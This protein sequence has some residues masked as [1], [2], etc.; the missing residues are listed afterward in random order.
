MAITMTETDTTSI[1]HPEVQVLV[2]RCAGC[3]ECVIRC[4]A[5]ALDMDPARWV[6]VAHD[7]RCVGCRQCV[8][9]CPFSAIEVH[10]PV[11]AG[12][13]V[14][15]EVV[16]PEPLLADV[17]E[18]RLGLRS[19]Q[20]AI[21]E[22]QRC[23]QC[24]D[25]T[26]VR[27]CPAHNDIPAFVAAVA[28]RDLT[29][30]HEVLRRTSVLPDVCARVCNQSAQCEG[31]CTWSLAGGVPVAIGQLERFVADMRPVPP[32]VRGD[33][34]GLSVA[35]VGAGPGGIGA[36]WALV[37]GGASVTV[38]ERDPV[39]AGLLGWG[40]PD[41]TLPETVAARPWRQL[42]DAGVDLHCGVE[43]DR[44]GLDRLL[45][46]H[47]AVVVATGASVP[48]RLPIPGADLDGVTD[49][50]AFLKSARRALLEGSL[51]TWRAAMGLDDAA[52]DHVPHVLVL[53]AGNTA[54]DVARTAR[55]LGLDA[56]CVDWL[57]ERF[58]LARPDEVAEAREEGVVV[59]FTRTVTSIEGEHG[60]VRQARLAPTLQERATRT[61]KVLRDA[62]AE[63]LDVDLV[64]M[65]M[66]YRPDP[67]VAG[68]LPGTPVRRTVRGLPDR[69]WTA[70]GLLANPASTFAF[71]NPVGRLALGREAGLQ[72]ASFPV[73]ER[74]WVVGDALVG[75]STVVEA[76]AQGR[77]A[78]QA[79]LAGRPSRPGRHALKGPARVLVCYASLGGR[80]AQ[81]ARTV[82]AELAD[83]GCAVRVLPIERVGPEELAAAD[84]LV[85]GTWVKGLVV[86]KVG[87]PPDVL[88]WLEGL[89]RLGGVPV[90]LFCTYAL[91]PRNTLVQM[92][93]RIEGH[94]A[95]V[96]TAAALR[97]GGNRV[98]AIAF[99]RRMLSEVRAL[100]ATASPR[101]PAT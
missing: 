71:S 26:C 27:G 17:G 86:A 1:V 98:A 69:R 96:V 15:A 20:E 79:V 64:V 32:P 93:S 43:I 95:R 56:T 28:A 85:I 81:V 7:E 53:G 80:T 10:G 94:G 68:S 35:V 73:R 6:V 78:A 70:S 76:M 54:M 75:P 63:A 45:T 8:R 57:D 3:Q 59:S 46:E 40:I 97:R 62:P 37:E 38:Y 100:G 14:T 99:A 5:D 12:T 48:V 65:A 42:E 51:A 33:D 22:A 13:R 83:K 4:P 84:A 31:A 21:A 11:L 74:L 55:R 90:A 89:P 39:P 72:A 91:D 58:S 44:A 36:A 24:P 18:V 19:W 52:C 82:G 30:A 87:P 34:V 92:G 49:A 88:A 67:A 2:D 77:R 61:P 60:R 41:F 25:P 66:G 29:R 50:T 23:L 101:A 47:D 16:H 9:T